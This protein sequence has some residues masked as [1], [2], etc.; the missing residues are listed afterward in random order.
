[1]TGPEMFGKRDLLPHTEDMRLLQPEVRDADFSFCE[2]RID[3]AL[4]IPGNFL[5]VVADV[6]VVS[7]SIE[8]LRLCYVTSK[9]M[10]TSR[11]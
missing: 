3:K 7:R 9:I 5:W 10:V 1:M 6:V 8:D 4:F 11:T 2:I